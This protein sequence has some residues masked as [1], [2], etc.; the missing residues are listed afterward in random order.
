MTTKAKTVTY[1]VFTLLILLPTAGSAIPELFSNG[2]TQT[3][4]A[5]HRL[6]YPLYLMR[7]TGFAK[8]LGAITLLAN[9]PLRFVEWAYAGFSILLL[10]ATTSHLLAGDAAHAPIPFTCFLIL[11]VS[12]TLHVQVRSASKT[13]LGPTSLGSA[14]HGE[15]GA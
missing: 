10:G 15:G 7:I 9:R 12:Y 11:L 5:L 6:G 14:L 3:I 4:E 13:A 2:P 8:L 1:W